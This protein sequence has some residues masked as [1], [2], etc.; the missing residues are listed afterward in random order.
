MAIKNLTLQEKVDLVNEIY[1]K[2]DEKIYGQSHAKDKIV[3]AFL[4]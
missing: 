3:K 1:L 2:L 4:S